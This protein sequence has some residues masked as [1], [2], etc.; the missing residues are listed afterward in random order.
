[1]GPRLG[2][3]PRLTD[4]LTVSRNVTLTVC[5]CC[6]V[7]RR[8][9]TRFGLLTG[10]I[11]S[12]LVVTTINY[13]TGPDLHN[14]QSLHALGFSVIQY[15]SPSNGSPHMH[16]YYSSLGSRNRRRGLN[17]R[18]GEWSRNTSTSC[19][20]P[21]LKDDEIAMR[22]MESCLLQYFSPKN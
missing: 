3:T 13:N 22:R 14:L 7:F 15:S 6:S 19:H 11:R 16:Q 17:N 9:E 20:S 1:M 21:W 10:F 18:L 2:L 8:L 12:S 4:W 5:E